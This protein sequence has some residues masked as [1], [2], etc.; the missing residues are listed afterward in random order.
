M[1][2]GAALAGA[3]AG[4]SQAFQ[5]GKQAGQTYRAN[6][7]Q[8]EQSAGTYQDQR[9]ASAQSLKNAKQTHAANQIKME[10]AQ[11]EADMYTSAKNEYDK[12]MARNTANNMFRLGLDD[13]VN[14]ID[15]DFDKQ[16]KSIAEMP[17]WSEFTNIKSLRK[18]NPTSRP[19]IDAA[20]SMILNGAP[21]A[22]DEALE[23]AILRM[24]ED[25]LLVM[26]DQGRA[27]DYTSLGMISGAGTGMSNS[28]LQKVQKKQLGT[29]QK[30]AKAATPADP[31]K[32]S[33]DF[34]KY[35]F[36]QIQLD[37]SLAK[38]YNENPAQALKKIEKKYNAQVKQPQIAASTDVIN[39]DQTNIVSKKE[40][41]EAVRTVQG[42]KDPLPAGSGPIKKDSVTRYDEMINLAKK[43]KVDVEKPIY[44][45][46]EK[47]PLEE[48]GRLKA[49]AHSYTGVD[50]KVI[51]NNALSK[52]L[53]T[54]NSFDFGNSTEEQVE[55]IKSGSGVGDQVWN[56]IAKFVSD[57]SGRTFQKVYRK[58]FNDL[59]MTSSKGHISQ[60]E[61]D[62][63]TEAYS[64]LS[65]DQRLVM[66]DYRDMVQA[67]A[68]PLFAAEA[69]NS[70]P[71]NIVYGEQLQN[72]KAIDNALVD[73]INSDREYKDKLPYKY[74]EIMA[75][76]T[77]EDK[78]D[79]AF[80]G[81]E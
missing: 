24:G 51:G 55:E 13:I 67:V 40:R 65:D 70:I 3:A 35:A 81:A 64:N 56:S 73:V 5:Q 8:M 2:L 9:L 54:L 63:L 38:L 12:G 37:P 1:N 16:N 10:Q 28:E 47:L 21:N 4:S 27:Q 69:K 46:M 29:L 60:A 45:Q 32:N 33:H 43:V 20:K 26:D 7:Q 42:K 41:L 80:G 34:T 78:I 77:E 68:S 44:E 39:D 15:M 18:F 58:T 49:A 79:D 23:A 36:G 74:P 66:Q 19:D 48:Q 72:F 52:Q 76:K 61:L 14:G 57:P 62:N 17:E 25:N 31:L 6:E 30:P 50:D 71:V 22:D 53:N 11:N 59:L 75:P